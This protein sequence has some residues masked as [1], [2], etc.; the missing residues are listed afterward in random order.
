[1]SLKVL[2]LIAYLAEHV[3]EFDE[4]SEVWFMSGPGLSSPV[5]GVMR[6]NE[7]DIVFE[8]WLEDDSD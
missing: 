3:D 5:R 4:E 2:E 6:L 7:S 1:M 8:T